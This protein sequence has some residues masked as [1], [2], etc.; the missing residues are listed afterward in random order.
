MGDNE[1]KQTSMTNKE[2]QEILKQYPDD[3]EII[4]YNVYQDMNAQ[5]DG[6]EKVKHVH[7]EIG[8]FE[9]KLKEDGFVYDEESEM[10]LVIPKMLVLF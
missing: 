9:A 4:R 2:L 6:Y 5:W 8:E 7:I 3:A 10:Y 1:E